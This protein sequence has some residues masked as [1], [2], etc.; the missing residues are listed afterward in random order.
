MKTGK[1]SFGIAIL[2][3]VAAAGAIYSQEAPAK[4]VID[5]EAATVLRQFKRSQQAGDCRSISRERH[6]RRCA[7]GR[8]QA[9]IC[10][11]PG[12]DR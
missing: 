3:L 7:A 2:L 12:N 10:S 8:P 11:Y 5:P 4:P 1:R 9:P 6:N